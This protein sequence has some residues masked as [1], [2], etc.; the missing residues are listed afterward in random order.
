MADN[1]DDEANFPYKLLLTN[2]QTLS[3]RKTF[4]NHTSVDIRLSNTHLTK[5][6]KGGFLKFLMALFQS[7]LPL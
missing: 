7:G 4:A 2:R 1:S 3:L 5:I 6:Q